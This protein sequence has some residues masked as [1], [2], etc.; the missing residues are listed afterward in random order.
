MWPS[1]SYINR[2]LNDQSEL[3]MKWWLANQLRLAML[4]RAKG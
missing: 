4:A 2:E 3:W 1:D